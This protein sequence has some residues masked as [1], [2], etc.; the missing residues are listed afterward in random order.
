M[1][2]GIL[3]KQRMFGDP[4]VNNLRF[5]IPRE[6]MYSLEFLGKQCMFGNRKTAHEYFLTFQ[7]GMRM[8]LSGGMGWGRGWES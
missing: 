8:G 3:G 1:C 7:N 6:A 4:W 5:G 2:V